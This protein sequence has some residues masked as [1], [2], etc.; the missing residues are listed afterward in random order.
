[1]T[2]N[3]TDTLDVALER[4]RSGELL[5]T[6]L[7]DFPA[8]AEV[9]SPLLEAATSLEAVRQV[10]MPAPEAWQADRADFL[11]EVTKLQ[12]QAVS[13]GLFV[14]LQEQVV[15]VLPW[16]IFNQPYSGRR[17]RRMSTLLIK[18]MLV[19]GLLFGSA[20]TT[21]TMASNSLPD[22]PLYPVKLALEDT[23][24]ALTNDPAEQAKLHLQKLLERKIQ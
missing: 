15:H 21:A 10:E 17:Q 20:G 18:A 6:I 11:T 1:M 3:V 7:A 4:L 5:A 12:Q 13:P 22:S 19:V 16:S 24:L 14:R 9:L 2:D 8:E 23:R